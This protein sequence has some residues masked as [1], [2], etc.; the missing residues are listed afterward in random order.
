MDHTS[1]G[2]SI[3]ELPMHHNI[4]TTG[5]VLTSEL[6]T[7]YQTNENCH[8]SH[9]PYFIAFLTLPDTLPHHKLVVTNTSLKKN[10][11]LHSS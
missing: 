5:N 11:G 1:D 10:A 3:I 9:H 8:L 4:I 2:N 7:V 6:F